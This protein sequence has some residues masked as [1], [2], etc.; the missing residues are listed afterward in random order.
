[1]NSPIDAT[2]PDTPAEAAQAHI[3]R[4]AQ[5]LREGRHDAAI[6]A[7]QTAAALGNADAMYRLGHA[8][9]FGLWA[10]EAQTAE[11]RQILQRAADLGSAAA[12]LQLACLALSDL[13]PETG[14]AIAARHLQQACARQHPL[15]QRITAMLLA[16]QGRH[17]EASALLAAAHAAGDPVAG[18]LL[19]RRL[20]LGIGIEADP[21]AAD[22]IRQPLRAMGVPVYLD[23]RAEADESGE[24]PTVDGIDFPHI[25]ANAG[26][27]EAQVIVQRLFRREDCLYLILCGTPHLR[28]SQV[29]D[30]ATGTLTRMG[31]RSSDGM[32]F[33]TMLEDAWLRHLQMRMAAA[34]GLPL[35]HA[36]PLVLLHYAPGQEY[37]PHR[38]Y[39]PDSDPSLTQATPGSAIGAGNRAAT[40]VVYLNEVSE[41]GET[42]FPELG[43]RVRPQAGYAASWRNLHRSGIRDP[44]SLHTGMPVIAGE[45][46][47]STLW[48]RER[49]LRAW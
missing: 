10:C 14:S 22:A 2:E 42:D 5:A 46:W 13:L 37:R 34:A 6:K 41:G 20:H 35:S 21:Q 36:E 1:M 29:V 4:A 40:T 44:R 19:A 3:E 28:A 30:P 12:D 23:E 15:A 48:I 43:Q 8:R 49:P 26:P 32:N 7:L 16:S 9:L 47:L 31:L 24:Q 18:A 25:P 38:D 39:L 45:K 27:D 11:A 17:R 33:D